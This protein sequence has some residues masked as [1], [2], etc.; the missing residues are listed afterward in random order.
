MKKL[1]LML[2][3]VLSASSLYAHGISDGD[4]Q[5]MIDG[6][7]LRYIELGASHMLTGYDHLLFLFGVMFF[8]AK[9]KD[10]VKFITAFTIGHC[11]TLIFATFMG[12]SANYFLVDAVIALTVIYKGFDNVD[13]FKKYLSMKSPNLLALVF[14]FGLIH[15][16]GLSTR[17][18][19]LPLGEDGLL[20]KILSFNV[21]VEVGQVLALSVMLI[22]LA[23]WRKRASFEQFSVAANVGLMLV[24]GLLF[25]MQMHGYSHEA[26]VDEFAFNKDAHHHEHAAIKAAQTAPAPSQSQAFQIN[27][28]KGGGDTSPET[29]KAQQDAPIRIRVLAKKGVEYKFYFAKDATTEYTWES[30]GGALF[31]DFHGEPTGGKKGY[32]KSFKKGTE[33]KSSGSITAPF[34]GTI[35]WYWQNNGSRDVTVSVRAQGDHIVMNE[36][37]R[38]RIAALI[39][40]ETQRQEMIRRQQQRRDQ[41]HG[42]SHGDGHGHSH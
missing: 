15:G 29:A 13:G 39:Q 6:G 34:S 21:G 7:Y 31:F 40:K 14:V 4:K 28:K 3:A 1:L 9:F 23:A 36:A 5:A 35:G 11:I 24:G 19:Q 17:L 2:A 18:Q 26:F 41:D 25:L 27:S 30:D 33:K 38:A 37:N 20:L 16:F 8:L 10:V 12:I 32:F 42:H 22:V